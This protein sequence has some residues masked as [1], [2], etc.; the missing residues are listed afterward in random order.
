[1]QQILRVVALSTAFVLAGLVLPAERAKACGSCGGSLAPIQEAYLANIGS[2]LPEA[3][4]WRL[5][6]S[7]RTATHDT[8]PH[9]GV[10][11]SVFE[12]RTTLVGA[13]T[14][15][16]SLTLQLLL[17][18]LLRN[19]DDGTNSR[20]E[21]GLGDSDFSARFR[22]WRSRSSN[23]EHALFVSGG[24]KIPVAR[25]VL[26]A[27]GA[28][29]GHALQLGTGSWDPLATAAYAASFGDFSLFAA[30]SVRIATRGRGGWQRGTAFVTSVALQ[31][32]VHPLLALSAGLD[33][34]YS[35]SDAVAGTRVAD[36]GGLVAAAVPALLFAVS[37]T[38]L[39]RAAI[40]VPFLHANAGTQSDSVA[41]SVS[42]V[43]TIAPDPEPASCP[44]PP[45]AAN[46]WPSQSSL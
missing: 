41:L 27:N 9:P 36:T 16:S 44:M 24:I 32:R 26:D 2:D 3:Q 31:W 29:A 20:R 35:Q 1:M 19:V 22:I 21:L 10:T 8:L 40:E 46:R 13:W 45:M 30:E 25:E 4:T 14:P 18:V 28:P 23:S 34:V 12:N 33:L 42:Y 11:E 5:G 6:L 15:W 43:I 7:N 38:S 17:P 39:L 37:D